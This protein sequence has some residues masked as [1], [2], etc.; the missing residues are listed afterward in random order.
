MFIFYP[1]GYSL[2]MIDGLII[3]AGSGGLAAAKRLAKYGKNVVLIEQDTIGGTCVSY[4][5]VPKKIWHA[6]AGFDHHATLAEA[7]GWTVSGLAFDWEQTQR[8][9]Q[10]YVKAL[11]DRH[12]VICEDLGITIVRG[13]ASFLDERTVAVNG[14]VY[15]PTHCLI[16]TGSTATQLSFPGAEFCETSIDFFS[17]KTQPNR[18]AIIGGGYIAVE[19]ASIL[20]AL[21]THVDIIIRGDTVLRGFD[22]DIRDLLNDQYQTRGI[23]IHSGV[24]VTAIQAVGSRLDVMLSNQSS[25]DVD[26]VIQ[27]V[28]REP[29]TASLQCKK[30]GIQCQKNRIIVND[31]YQTSNPTI[32][33]VG[34][35]IARGQL[36]P[37]AIAQARQWVDYIV[38]DRTFPVSFDVIPTA[39]FSLPEAASVGLSESDAKRQFSKVNCIKKRFFPLTSALMNQPKDPV[40]LKLVLEGDDERVIGIHMVGEGASEIIQCLAVAVQK[41]ITK[42]DLDYTMALHPSITEELVTIY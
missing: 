36:T 7:N 41:G 14:R 17:W 32:Y 18:V 39:V 10:A 30:S 19:L 15:T 34:D 8:N 5:C 42:A 33:A 6:V 40:L 4:G 21:G 35:C 37:I 31:K 16:A 3:G 11:N 25:I 27:C 23:C 26:H 22:Q 38:A 9:I 20:Q 2:R 29:N 1:L 12:Q 24:T 13:T 28:G